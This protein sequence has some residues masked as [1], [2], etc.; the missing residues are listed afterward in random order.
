MFFSVILLLFLFSVFFIRLT[1]RVRR[2]LSLVGARKEWKVL[3][4]EIGQSIL[5]RENRERERERKRDKWSV[6]VVK[7]R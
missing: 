1:K 6:F 7:A 2:L 4:N 5:E 3:V